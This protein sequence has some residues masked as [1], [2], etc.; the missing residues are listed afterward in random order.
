[1]LAK[2][3]SLSLL[4]IAAI[5]LVV[6]AA[7]WALFSA[8]TSNVNNT[9]TAGTVTLDNPIGFTCSTGTN[10]IAPGDSGSCSYSVT[11][12][13]SLDAWLGIDTALAGGLTTC[14]GG[15]HF[16]VIVSDGTNAYSASG[17]N[18]VVGAAP[19]SGGY[20]LN[21][22]ANWSLAL[23]AGNPCQAESAT[24]DL[25]VHAVQSRNNTNGA[26]TGPN[27]WN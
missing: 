7:S 3:L 4:A 22:T 17:M 18:Q 14:D 5:S 13:G 15:G 12:T 25:M 9:F 26:G 23:A 21:L 19:V 1:M 11:Y 16:N 27:A 10:N 2:R 20:T 6:T 24:L 8:T